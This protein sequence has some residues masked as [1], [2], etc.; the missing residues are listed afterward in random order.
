MHIN[1]EFQLALKYYHSGNFGQ[2]ASICETILEMKPDEIP[3]LHF[4]GIIYQQLQNYD[5]AIK[6]LKKALQ[7]DRNSF[8]GYYNLGSAFHK[9]GALNE[10]MDCYQKVLQINPKFI[11]ACIK[12]GNVLQSQGRL[13]EAISCY[14]NAIKINPNNAGV[15]FN[16]GVALQDKGQLDDAISCYQKAI[17]LSLNIAGVYNNLGLALQ[18]KGRIDEAIINYK[19]ALELDP[20]F[21]EVHYNLGLAFQNIGQTEEAIACYQKSLHHKPDYVEAYINLGIAFKDKGQFDEAVIN[22]Q[23]AIHFNPISP[24]AYNNLGLVLQEKGQ[25]DEAIINYHK[26]VNFNPNFADAYLNLGLALKGQGK[27]DEAIAV[28]DKAILMDPYNFRARFAKCISQLPIIYTKQADI[29]ICRNRYYAELTKLQDSISLKSLQNIKIAA[30]AVGTQQPFYLAYQGLNDR[31]LQQLY[32]NLIS[33]VM[34]LRYPQFSDR[35]AM[36][37]HSSEER[38]RI[39]FVSGFFRLHSNWKIPIKGWIENMDKERFSLYGYYTGNKK[40][41]AT[42]DARS[43]FDRFAEDV[44]SFEELC[45]IIREDNLHVLIYPEI[46][47]DP[48][49]VR[50]AA[51]RLAPIQCT[52]WG[53]PD[54]SGLPTIDYFL[55][56]DLMEPSDAD[57]HYTEKLIR[58]PN[59]SIYYTSLDFPSADINR[60]IFNLRK[61]SVLYLCCQSLF[62]YL[63]RYDEIYPRIAKEVGDCQFI[64]ISHKSSYVTEQFQHRI[65]QSFNKLGLKANNYAVFLPRLDA[66]EYNA[67]NSLSDIYLDSVGWSGCNSTFEAVAYDLP[68]VTLPGEL[69]R[70]RH[71]SAILTMMEVTETIA[72]SLDT[73]VELAVRLGLDAEWRHLI[74]RKISNNKHLIYRDKTCIAA[75]EGFLEKVVNNKNAHQ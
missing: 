20:D 32:G 6:F 46:G 65:N 61:E 1:S 67:I 29:Q 58:L 49:S 8:E 64:F 42:E 63:P 43:Y 41:K 60:E 16:L 53:H 68:I 72:S 48:K 10:A 25:L 30:E 22:F 14:Q 27:Q 33:R 11:D 75:L 18:N 45:R 21:A 35:P 54:T 59:L 74:S 37:L 3:V 39:G 12:L 34:C 26:A 71:S 24:D 57:S 70:G 2:A 40:D 66:L 52:S 69:M 73:Y 38:L 55:S 5:A 50:L 56:S 36:P 4:L 28:Y 23:K 31:E 9:K 7:L 44:N 51:L 13:E 47:M 17:A 19:K 15:Y 62:K